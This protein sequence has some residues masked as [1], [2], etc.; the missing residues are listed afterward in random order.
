VQTVDEEPDHWAFL[1]NP[2]QFLNRRAPDQK[3]EFGLLL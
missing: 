2:R 1:L 3:C